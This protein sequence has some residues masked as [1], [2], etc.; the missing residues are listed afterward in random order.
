LTM[1]LLFTLPRLH[2]AR[3]RRNRMTS[4]NEGQ[5]CGTIFFPFFF[6]VLK[7]EDCSLSLLLLLYFLNEATE[8]GFCLPC[9]PLV[10]AL[11]WCSAAWHFNVVPDRGRI[12]RL[13]LKA[14]LKR[15][16]P[17]V[18]SSRSTYAHSPISRRLLCSQQPASPWPASADALQ[19]SKEC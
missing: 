5:L 19:K 13:E 2:N 3:L 8:D 10:Q 7:T 18:V 16:T 4:S 14:S 1:L 9:L 15:A 12:M 11:A 17:A 6:L